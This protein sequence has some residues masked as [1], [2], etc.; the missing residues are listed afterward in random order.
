M[1]LVGKRIIL[2]V[3][4]PL[5]YIS[6]AGGNLIEAQVVAYDQRLA[7]E[8]L[9]AETDQDVIVPGKARGKRLIV[10]TRHYGAKLQDIALGK[11][12]VVGVAIVEL[13]KADDEAVYSLIGGISIKGRRIKSVSGFR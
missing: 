5:E 7:A 11:Q 2:S 6:H 8:Q 4:E 1:T 13:G 9:I 12:V 3:D 10:K